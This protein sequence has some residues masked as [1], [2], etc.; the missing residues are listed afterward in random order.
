[1]NEGDDSGVLCEWDGC[2]RCFDTEQGMKT[3]HKRTHGVSIAGVKVV[4][5]ECDHPFRVSPS[6]AKRRK[7]C[8][9]ECK[10][11][12]TG[13]D[14]P[15]WKGGK[16][17][18]ICESCGNEYQVPRT[19]TDRS[20]YCS[21]KCKRVGQSERMTGRFV[22][23]NSPRWKGGKTTLFCENCGGE[24][25]RYPSEVEGSNYC[26][27]ACKFEGAYPTGKEHP[28]WKGRE[29]NVCENCGN[30]YDR[31]PSR[32]DRS[33]YCSTECM[34]EDY[35]TRFSGEGGSSWGGGKVSIVCL[36]CGD[37]YKEDPHRV[38]RS[39][40]CSRACQDE[41][42][43]IRFSGKNHPRWKGGPKDYY[44]PSWPQAR[45]ETR[46]RDGYKCVIC[47]F[48]DRTHK[49]VYGQELHTHH[50]RKFRL[51]GIDN[52]EIANRHTNLVTL[53]R[54][55]H[56]PFEGDPKALTLARWEAGHSLTIN[57]GVDPSRRQPAAE[58]TPDQPPG[59]QPGTASQTRV[60]APPTHRPQ[61]LQ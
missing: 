26:S 34:S 28:L 53:C 22:G 40:Y 18:L 5:P 19:R 42:R 39:N 60:S 21:N 23:E 61:L 10:A 1:M 27:N 54:S 48:P 43:P 31:L 24:Y 11:S 38:Q 36:N 33:T 20:K 50:I 41:H 44:G 15:A 59:N 56:A 35:K 52:H 29:I 12:Q 14:H 25:H 9:V 2:E 7:Y 49:Y 8:S 16:P 32:A 4:C 55:H 46:K 51:F 45:R 58:S 47:G 30:E 13:P 6:A 37:E 17:T 57:S 3:H